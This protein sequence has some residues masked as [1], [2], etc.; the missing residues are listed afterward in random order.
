MPQDLEILVGELSFRLTDVDEDEIGVV[1]RIVDGPTELLAR[2]EALPFEQN[3]DQCEGLP[4]RV[5][6]VEGSKEWSDGLLLGLDEGLLHLFADLPAAPPVAPSPPIPVPEVRCPQC[7]RL[8]SGDR[9]PCPGCGWT[10]APMTDD[11]GKVLAETFRC[12]GTVW[13][14]VFS[15]ILMTAAAIIVAWAGWGHGRARTA[16]FAGTLLLLG[17]GL[18]IVQILRHRLLWVRIDPAR[19]IDTPGSGLVPWQAIASVE[20]YAGLFNYRHTIESISGQISNR[21][22]MYFLG[23]LY[24][25]VVIL[26]VIFLP[27]LSVISPWHARVTIILKNG[28]RILLRDLEAPERFI[29]M[30]RY[31]IG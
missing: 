1:G 20:E 29:R 8:F 21:G 23:C 27:V 13:P 31:K 30:L 6:E 16:L 7:N 17:P 26:M 11:A 3:L 10:K 28:G 14:F 22:L 24:V 12:G 5:R 9:T 2:L 4:C 19:G 25:P 15:G 18:A